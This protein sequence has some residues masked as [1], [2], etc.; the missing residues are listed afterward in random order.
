[1]MKDPEQMKTPPRPPD[2]ESRLQVLRELGIL[3][4]ESDDWLD[5]ITAYCCSR[6]RVPISLVSLV[7]EDRQWFMSCRGLP[8]KETPRSVS[9]CGHAVADDSMLVVADASA[10]SRFSDNP[11][12]SND[13]RIRFYAGSPIRVKGQPIGTLCIID[14][15]VRGLTTEDAAELSEIADAVSWYLAHQ[16]N[17]PDREHIPDDDRASRTAGVPSSSSAPDGGDSDPWQ[18][19]VD[20]ISARRNT[21]EARMLA[22]VAFGNRGAD[23]ERDVL[24]WEEEVLDPCAVSIARRLIAMRSTALQGDTALDAGSRDIDHRTSAVLGHARGSEDR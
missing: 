15:G 12:V 6:F 23:Q 21:V 20:Y 10:D 1:M 5:R 3:D 22:H 17:A 4:S 7:D 9:F 16:E 8:V 11:L 14:Q 13:P 24:A 18:E 19:A 2:E